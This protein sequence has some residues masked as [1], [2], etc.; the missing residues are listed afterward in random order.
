MAVPIV[1]APAGVRIEKATADICEMYLTGIFVFQLDQTAAAAAIAQRFP[2]LFRKL[3]QRLFPK[4]LIGSSAF[5]LP[6]V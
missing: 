5:K 1:M 2:L 3:F 6:L 4:R